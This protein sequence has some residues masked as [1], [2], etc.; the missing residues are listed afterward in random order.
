MRLHSASPFCMGERTENIT[1][2]TA[3]TLINAAGTLLCLSDLPLC[4]NHLRSLT[5]QTI[6]SLQRVCAVP[7]TMG[8]DLLDFR[9]LLQNTCLK[10]MVALLLKAFVS[11]PQ[12]DKGLGMVLQLYCE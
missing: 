9:A 10:I 2:N 5:S 1:L 6:S 11:Q 12:A 3:M 4:L 8:N 7:Q